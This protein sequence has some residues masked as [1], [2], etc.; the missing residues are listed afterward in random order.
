MTTHRTP[1]AQLTP[2]QLDRAW[3][4]SEGWSLLLV[5]HQHRPAMPAWLLDAIDSA[6]GAYWVHEMR[7]EVRGAQVE[8]VTRQT[9][10]GYRPVTDD[11]LMRELI[12]ANRIWLDPQAGAVGKMWRAGSNHEFGF[13]GETP[14]IAVMR[15]VLAQ[16][17]PL[18][19]DVIDTRDN[20]R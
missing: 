13:Y 12:V 15:V 18:G 5:T 4:E 11:T 14:N 6:C 16:R 1:I 3:M 10:R 8:G 2:D 19:Y 7:Q 9:Q 17:Y 20:S